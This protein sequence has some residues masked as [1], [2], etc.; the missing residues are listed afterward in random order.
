MNLTALREKHPALLP[1]LLGVLLLAVLLLLPTGYE[2][3]YQNADRVKALV[4]ETDDS[5][6]VDTGLIRSGEQRCRVRLLGGS[7]SGQETEA[8]NRLSGSLAQ[9]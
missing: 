4:L 3:T 2:V 9:D 1:V 6:I 8:V 7:F 5:S